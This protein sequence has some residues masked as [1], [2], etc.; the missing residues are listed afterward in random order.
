[1]KFKC[2]L[3]LEPAGNN[4]T[5][6]QFRLDLY[7]NLLTLKYLYFLKEYLTFNANI[8]LL[9]YVWNYKWLPIL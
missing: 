8:F 3:G 5:R 1:M 2:K 4:L 6:E 9:K 7:L